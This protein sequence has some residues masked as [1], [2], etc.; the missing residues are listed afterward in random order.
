MNPILKDKINRMMS[1]TK[2][3]Y[4][5]SKTLYKGKFIELIEEDYILPNQVIMKRERIVKNHQKDAVIIVARTKDNH[6][7]LVSQN[8]IN[9]MTTLEF[10]SGYVEPFESVAEASKRELLEETGYSCE[11]IDIF[12]SYYTQLGIDSSLVYITLATSCEKIGSQNLGKYEYIL[13]DTFSYD[14]LRELIQRQYILGVGNKLAF[15]EL[16][17]ENPDMIRTLRR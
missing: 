16:N 17:Y 1:Q 9:Q 2:A 11:K 12:D 13:Y 10:P 15:Y 8:R 3:T 6:Y 7:I 14:E 5:D 4:L